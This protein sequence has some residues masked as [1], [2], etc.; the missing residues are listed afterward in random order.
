[1]NLDDHKRNWAALQADQIE[2]EQGVIALSKAV[3]ELL[4]PPAG[5][6]RLFHYF[7]D[8]IVRIRELNVVFERIYQC[9]EKLREADIILEARRPKTWPGGTRYPQ[10]IVALQDQVTRFQLDL[11]LDFQTM[12]IFSGMLLDEVAQIYGHIFGMK[13]PWR[14]T[15]DI[16]AKSD[17]ATPFDAIWPSFHEDILWLDAVPRLFRNKMMVHREQPWQISTSHSVYGLD[18]NFW[19]PIAASW[20][21]PDEQKTHETDILAILAKAN[22][23]PSA[24]RGVH[25]AV[26]HGL[27]NIAKFDR[28]DRKALTSMAARVGFATPSFHVFGP[29]IYRFI[30]RFMNELQRQVRLDTARVDLGKR[31]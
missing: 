21:T 26:F 1:M 23:P 30:I 12:L 2:A 16:I 19:V 4:G 6:Y 14:V 13:S 22:L 7:S 20:Y 17:G 3:I 25:A 18:W 8:V 9:R 24:N 5:P 15:F 11:S 27:D 28:D 10:E 31:Q 29:R